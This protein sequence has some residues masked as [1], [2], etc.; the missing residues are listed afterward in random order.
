[1]I[2]TINS[3]SIRSRIMRIL[4]D[5]GPQHVRDIESK[6][7][8]VTPKQVESALGKLRRDKRIHR[9]GTASRR[10]NQRYAAG[11]DPDMREAELSDPWRRQELEH[12][13]LTN[14]HLRNDW[15]PR[16]DPAAAWLFN[17]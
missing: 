10:R 12:R 8:D 11:S 5:E 4:V 16:P 1:M 3:P 17:R 6:L 7:P 2:W 13:L 15:M 9:K 14:P